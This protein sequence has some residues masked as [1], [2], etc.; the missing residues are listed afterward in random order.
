M[1]TIMLASRIVL[2]T[3]ENIIITVLKKLQDGKMVHVV[4]ISASHLHARPITI[5]MAILARLTASLI[6]EVTGSN[7]SLSNLASRACAS[8]Q[9]VMSIPLIKVKA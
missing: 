1:F 3:A 4:I 5:C 8:V 9:A 6:A 7:V 2:R